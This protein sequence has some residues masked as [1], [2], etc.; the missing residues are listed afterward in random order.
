MRPTEH[1]TSR[2]TYGQPDSVA[3]HPLQR[4]PRKTAI[5]RR[6]LT[7]RP[8]RRGLGHRH[9]AG[10]P[11][12]L[13]WLEWVRLPKRV[14]GRL[15]STPSAAART[16]AGAWS[17]EQRDDRLVSAR[18][19]A[20]TNI[21]AARSIRARYSRF[22][23]PFRVGVAV[24]FLVLVEVFR[25]SGSASLPAHLPVRLIHSFGQGLFRLGAL[26]IGLPGQSVAD[27][28]HS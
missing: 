26:R 23:V 22:F 10:G 7:L 13:I 17:L 6:T 5:Q 2:K 16:R 3:V 20:T 25:D 4:S 27:Q 24:S 18:G 28:S 9:S 19:L 15:R 21:F 1:Q 12:N 11:S 8:C 14:M